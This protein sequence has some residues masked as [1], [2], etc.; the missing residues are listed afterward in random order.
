MQVNLIPLVAA[1]GTTRA[2]ARV[3]AE[4]A[5]ALG[6]YTW[7]YHAAGTGYA[8]RYQMGRPV[9][10]HRQIM[11]AT[12]RATEVDHINQDGLDNR[13]ANLRLATH[14]Q[15]RQNT[16]AHRGSTSRF[17]GVHWDNAKHKWVAAARLNSKE[18]FIGRF[19]SEMEA[20]QAAS[21]WRVANMPFA[22]EAE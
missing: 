8:C 9:L 11:G 18:H 12:E 4:D 19:T 2:Y 14:A 16:P 7:H 15:N 20:A 1:D 22:V 5:E 13:R 10:M 3:D 6:S 17:R 21:Q